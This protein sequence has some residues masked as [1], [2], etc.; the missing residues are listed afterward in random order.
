MDDKEVWVEGGIMSRKGQRD[1]NRQSQITIHLD[2][3]IVQ[4][5]D[6]LQNTFGLDTRA[7]A[8]LVLIKAGMSAIP[9]ETAVFETCRQ[10]VASTRKHLFNEM[11]IFFQTQADMYRPR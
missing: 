8:A 2:P 10:A 1:P 7:S 3:E 5:L 6:L 11:A 4:H 9:M